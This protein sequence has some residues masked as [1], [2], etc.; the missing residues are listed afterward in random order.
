M[1][2]LRDMW[3]SGE[4]TLGLWASDPSSIAAEGLGRAGVEYV[5]VDNQ[6][7]LVDY[8]AT[9]SMIQGILVGGSCPIVRVPWN[10]PGIIGKMLDAGAQG[11]IIPMVN[12]PTEAQAAVAAGRY[13]PLGARS[14]GP[15]GVAPRI[16]GYFDSS[17]EQ[18]AIIP[19][20][21]T[22]EALGN[23]DEIVS[24]PGVDAVYVGPA[25]LSI[26]LGLP[27]GN[28]DDAPGFVDAL[29]AI[30][31]ACNRAGVVPGIHSSGALTP[32]R[33]EM[34]FRMVTVTTD[35]VAMRQ[36][37]AAEL[38]LARESNSAT[39]SPPGSIY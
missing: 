1:T 23:I 26:S 2:S 21:E 17:A 8:Q 7:G 28:N 24:V 34:G 25:D 16:K 15:T 29:E 22:V 37:V 39:S 27:P 12:T 30:V 14:Y 13:P 11:V 3:R 19:M 9:V 18:I 6:H 31:A 20:V 36:G 5:C 33:L 32:R 4:T 38:A 35:L 10:E